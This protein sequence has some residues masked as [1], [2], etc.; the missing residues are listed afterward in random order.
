[1]TSLSSNKNKKI[2]VCYILSYRCPN[3]VRTKTLIAALKRMDNVI[4]YEAINTTKGIFRYIQ[5]LSRLLAIR[6]TKKADYYILGFRGYEIF[7]IVRILA[8]GTPLIF[9]HMMSPYDSLLNERKI[10]K[11][12]RPIE[13]LIYLYE[14]SILKYSDVILTDTTIHRK[15]FANL[16]KEQQEKIY[17]LHVGTDEN[18]FKN[19]PSDNEVKKKDF[20]E[21]F[22]YG[23]FL[24]LHGIDIILKAASIVKD[25]PIRFTLIGGKKK[26]LL[27]FYE[28]KKRL[29]LKNVIHKERV[30]YE[31][32]PSMI[33]E[34]DLCLGGPFGN[35]GQAR[36]VVSGKTFQFLAMGKPTIVGKIDAY[37]G[38]EDKKNCLLVPQGNEKKLA[39][40]I[41]WCFENQKKLGEIGQRGLEL[42][43]TK[44]SIDHIK[45][46]LQVIFL[47]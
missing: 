47:S 34:S 32:L 42:Y 18:L 3:Y 45:E 15:Y 16:F 9:D 30:D 43:R 17:A 4:L 29:K 11:K 10:F 8:L 37:Y 5:T 36:R 40:T 41:L 33:S 27:D 44:F 21:V 7:W 35:T 46:A 39:N 25:R 38:F 20:F 28:I 23:T 19:L 22:F 1:M 6:M 14:K 13:K 12:G 2:K 24:P 31:Q 26:Y